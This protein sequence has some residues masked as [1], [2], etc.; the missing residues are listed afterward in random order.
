MEEFEIDDDLHPID[1]P[2]GT[3][4][5]GYCDDAVVAWRWDPEGQ[6][7]LAVCEQHRSWAT[8]IE[9]PR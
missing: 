6:R 5:W 3:C 1:P 8:E 9:V 7:F 4:D 2:Y